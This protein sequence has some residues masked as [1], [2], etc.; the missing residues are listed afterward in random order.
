M[1]LSEHLI[2]D[3]AI[4]NLIFELILLFI[5]I[6]RAI[7]TFGIFL[8][9]KVD[10]LDKIF[11]VKQIFLC[12]S[13]TL[14]EKRAIIRRL[15]VLIE[16]LRHLCRR[17]KRRK[18]QS[19]KPRGRSKKLHVQR[20]MLSALQNAVAVKIPRI[21]IFLVPCI[22]QYFL[23][24][25]PVRPQPLVIA[26]NFPFAQGLDNGEHRAIHTRTR[27][28]DASAK[29]QQGSEAH[30]AVFL[31]IASKF[32]FTDRAFQIGEKEAKRICIAP[33]MRTST[34]TRPLLAVNAFPSVK[35]TVFKPQHCRRFQNGH[36]RRDC[37]N[38][39]RIQGRGMQR[40]AERYCFLIK[41]ITVQKCIESGSAGI[42]IT[43]GIV[44]FPHD[45]SIVFVLEAP[46]IIIAIRNVPS[47][48]EACFFT[49]V[50][51]RA[52]RTAIRLAGFLI[53][54]VQK[55]SLCHLIP[56]CGNRVAPFA[57]IPIFLYHSV[58]CIH[59]YGKISIFRILRRDICITEHHGRIF[60]T[61]NDLI[62]CS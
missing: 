36:R 46:P 19:L 11:A 10:L 33:N 26:A 31:Y 43:C 3:R 8:T 15:F 25:I 44:I 60:T 16:I 51:G 55:R 27:L 49:L 12:I 4:C 29:R 14:F 24:G 50:K 42:F 30:F 53:M 61:L 17:R 38:H 23:N 59:R 22:C 20:M 62:F 5:P 18:I 37:I 58:F 35:S 52:D 54:T 57:A 13:I 2:D 56:K 41:F 39:G 28:R 34:L 45:V 1:P 21:G 47:E 7:K 40:I 6:I 9:G 48:D 32:R